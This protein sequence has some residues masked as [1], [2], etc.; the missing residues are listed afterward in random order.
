M[1][2]ISKGSANEHAVTE[3][4]LQ[5]L[6]YSILLAKFRISITFDQCQQNSLPVKSKINFFLSLDSIVEIVNI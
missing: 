5:L 3:L 6:Y 4:N 1:L 2:M